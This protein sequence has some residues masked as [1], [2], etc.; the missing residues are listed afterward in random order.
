MGRCRRPIPTCAF[1]V[2]FFVC[3]FDAHSFS[4]CCS[5]IINYLFVHLCLFIV[6]FLVHCL[7]VC[8]F[9][10]SLFVR[11]LSP[12][13]FPSNRLIVDFLFILPPLQLLPSLT[14]TTNQCHGCCLHT[15][16][17]HCHYHR[18]CHIMFTTTVTYRHQHCQHRHRRC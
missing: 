7:F 4:V 6:H 13:P 9:I 10:S 3:S 18:G 15:A 12:P 16:A 11:L 2:H 1:I 14:T 17:N 5:L 8:L